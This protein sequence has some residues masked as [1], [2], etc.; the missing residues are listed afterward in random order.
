MRENEKEGGEVEKDNGSGNTTL[1]MSDLPSPKGTR[2]TWLVVKRDGK[3]IYPTDDFES[4]C[5][6][7][8][9]RIVGSDAPFR[10]DLS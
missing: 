4:I 5:R 8:S 10:T 7:I 9:A 3:V 6:A 2:S 1:Y